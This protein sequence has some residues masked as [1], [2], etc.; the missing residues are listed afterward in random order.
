MKRSFVFITIPAALVVIIGV[1]LVLTNATG[2]SAT[3]QSAAAVAEISFSFTRQ[4]GSA[5]NQFAVWIEDTQGRHVK[6]VFATNYTANGGWR[7]RET[8]I[9]QWVKQSGL[10]NM[11]R[12]QIDALS[13][14][15][16]RNGNLTYQWDG[17]DSGNVVLPP[18]DY[19]II[20]EA[21][22]RWANQV[23]YSAPIRLGQGPATP[24]VTVE[25]IGN[26]GA[27]QSMIRDVTVKTLR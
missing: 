24:E 8:S 11:T 21:T 22:L 13:G 12:A 17:T 7:L 18:G 2:Q 6:T 4:S 26:P 23:Y 15:T 25:Y 14:A 10:A 16:P 3:S 1:V 9:P 27:E 19:V 20:L 5:S